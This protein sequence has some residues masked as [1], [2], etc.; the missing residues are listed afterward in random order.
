MKELTEVMKNMDSNKN[1]TINFDEF[2]RGMYEFV[3][4]HKTTA[5]R[6]LGKNDRVSYEWWM[7]YWLMQYVTD[8]LNDSLTGTLTI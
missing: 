6:R 8:W 7:V 5:E 4:K 3:V 1:G 2:V